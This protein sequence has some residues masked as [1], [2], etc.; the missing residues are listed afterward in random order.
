MPRFKNE[1]KPF[2]KYAKPKVGKRN[3]KPAAKR[4]V[5]KEKVQLTHGKEW[6][7]ASTT[8]RD[9]LAKALKAEGK[10]RGCTP[11]AHV[12]AAFYSDPKAMLDILKHMLPTLKAVEAKVGQATP[13]KLL[14]DYTPPKP[15][16]KDKPDG[17]DTI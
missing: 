10:R 3:V 17:D 12:A 1:P 2:T 8:W 13:F 14:I 4:H 16:K 6:E 7:R 5:F 9:E 15:K 11:M